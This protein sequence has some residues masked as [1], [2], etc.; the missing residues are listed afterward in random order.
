M[1]KSARAKLRSRAAEEEARTRAEN[2]AERQR[3]VA[4]WQR[5]LPTLTLLPP[6]WPAFAGTPAKGAV[7]GCCRRNDYRRTEA[8]FL[9]NTCYPGPDCM[10]PL[11]TGYAR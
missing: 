10:R 4:V 3:V 8:S 7:C 2:E 9:C 11:G 1:A 6:S 5:Y